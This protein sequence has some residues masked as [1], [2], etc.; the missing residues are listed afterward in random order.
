MDGI[1]PIRLQE[2]TCTYAGVNVY[3]AR[4]KKKKECVRDKISWKFYF[5][6]WLFFLPFSSLDE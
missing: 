3:C 2:Y 6:G 1:K 5:G 4:E